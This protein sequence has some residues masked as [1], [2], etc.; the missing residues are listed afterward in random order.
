MRKLYDDW[1]LADMPIPFLAGGAAV[2]QAAGSAGASVANAAAKKTA[3]SAGFAAALKSAAA[4]QSTGAASQASAQQAQNN[5]QAFQQRLL[6]LMANSQVDTSQ[7]IRLQSDGQGG[8]QVDTNSA[9]ADKI[10]TIFNEHPELVAQF[11]T[12]AQ[13][14]TQL[15]AAD[16]TQA[17][18][19]ALHPVTFGLQVNGQ[20]V[21]V[22]FA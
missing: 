21:Q 19:D 6:Q 10:K 2:V 18:A 17:A 1:L 8:V 4:R 16:P 22:S 12:L 14:F 3:G 11:Q 13:Q 5:L 7:E 9:D 15:R 20:Q